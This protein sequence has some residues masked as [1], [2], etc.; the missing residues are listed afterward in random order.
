MRHSGGVLTSVWDSCHRSASH[1]ETLT[2]SL[3]FSELVSSPLNQ[4]S[5]KRHLE[6]CPLQSCGSRELETPTDTS[7][8]RMNKKNV[9]YV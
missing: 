6:N 9:T 4:V 3:P 8:R 7:S 5:L 2:K 1:F